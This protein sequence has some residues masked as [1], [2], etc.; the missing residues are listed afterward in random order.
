[1]RTRSTTNSCVSPSRYNMRSV[2]LSRCISTC[3]IAEDKVR[4]RDATFRQN[5]QEKRI[6]SCTTPGKRTSRTYRMNVPRR[7][8]GYRIL[9]MLHDVVPLF[10]SQKNSQKFHGAKVSSTL[11][12]CGTTLSPSLPPCGTTVS[13]SL[14]PCGTTVSPSL[15]PCGT[16]VSH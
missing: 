8:G 12:S 7:S 16:T 5:L 1:M 6:T 13:P 9:R 10:I 2:N 14:P 4:M 15:P 11:Q 3:R